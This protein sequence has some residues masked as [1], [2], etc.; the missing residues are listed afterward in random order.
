M[1]SH[2]ALQII[3]ACTRST[4]RG[5]KHFTITSFNHRHTAIRQVE[6]NEDVPTSDREVNS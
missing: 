2:S 3:G 6:R 5:A 1:F 4:L